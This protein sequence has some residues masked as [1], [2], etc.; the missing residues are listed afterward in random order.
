MPTAVHITNDMRKD[1]IQMSKLYSFARRQLGAWG[2]N[3]GSQIA[4]AIKQEQ[5]QA[6]KEIYVEERK[7]YADEA[8]ELFKKLCHAGKIRKEQQKLLRSLIETLLGSYAN[9]YKRKHYDNEFHRLYT[10]LKAYHLDKDDW[11][12]IMTAL[13]QI[14]YSS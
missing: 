4:K 5:K 8:R 7:E 11:D 2:N 10:Y 6:I 13:E 1:D 9:E 3:V 12:K 14:Q